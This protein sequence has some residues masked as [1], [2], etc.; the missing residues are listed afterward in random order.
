MCMDCKWP[1]STYEGTRKLLGNKRPFILTRAGYSG[2][3]RY[4]AVWTGDNVS[5]DDHM[6]TGVR[7]LNSLGL[8]GVPYTGMDVGGFTGG[9]SKELFGRWISIGAF[10]PFFRIHSGIDS[11]EADPMEL[12]RTERKPSTKTTSACATNCCPYLYSTFAEAN[13]NGMPVVRTLAINH[14]FNG[15]VYDGRFQNQF[16]FGPSIM[17]CPIESNKEIM[18][19]LFPDSDGWYSLYDDNYTQGGNDQMVECPI[20][21]FRFM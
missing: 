8:A 19:V 17:V 13:R 18:K 1:R 11:K 5:T 9:P 12:W 20:E 16:Y 3:Q 2:I 15:S 6:M 4:S 14:P 7:L 21:S 10:S